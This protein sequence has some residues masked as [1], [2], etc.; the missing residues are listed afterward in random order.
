MYASTQLLQDLKFPFQS[1]AVLRHIVE[2]FYLL[3]HAGLLGERV[4]CSVG[5]TKRFLYFNIGQRQLLY[6]FFANVV[7]VSN[8]EWVF[9][10]FES[11]VGER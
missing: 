11:D 6:V 3:K 10:D 7:G 8:S 9:S 4:C 5:Q 1:F 2:P